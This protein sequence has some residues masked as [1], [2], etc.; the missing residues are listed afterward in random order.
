MEI[1]R[2]INPSV[3]LLE[4]FRF[5]IDHRWPCLIRAFPVVAITAFLAWLQ[6]N[7]LAQTDF[8][9]LVANELLYAIFAVYWHRYT[10]LEDQRVEAGFGLNFGLREIKFAGAMLGY[11]LASYLLARAFFA[12]LGSGSTSSL[13]VFACLLL[14]VFLP[15]IL[16]FPAIALDQPIRLSLCIRRIFDIMLP[17]I[18]TVLLGLVAAAGVYLLIFL[19]AG[20]LATL[21]GPSFAKMLV[22]TIASFLVMP[23]VM[24]VAISFVS[25]LF[26]DLMG[27]PPSRS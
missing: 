14:L 17:L 13:V 25:I 11:V 8:F 19:P 15:F 1:H 27:V 26:R 2:D 3:C 9:I 22:S 6:T 4:A 12:T 23:F 20:F 5:V 16:I 21:F 24:A 18:G 7:I 10:V